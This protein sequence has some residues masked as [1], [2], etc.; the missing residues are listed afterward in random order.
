MAQTQEPQPDPRDVVNS[1]MQ[2][3]GCSMQWFSDQIGYTRTMVSRVLNKHVA[4]SKRMA[5]DIRST[6]PDLEIDWIPDQ[7]CFKTSNPK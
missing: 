5:R 1:W 3:R 7:P 2:A 6:F 4:M